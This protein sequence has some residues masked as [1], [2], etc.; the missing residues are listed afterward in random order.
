M[1]TKSRRTRA[2]DPL[3]TEIEQEF[4]LGQ[5]IRYGDMFDFVAGLELEATRN[6]HNE[7]AFSLSHMKPEILSHLGRKEDAL[8]QAW[9]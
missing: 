7:A 1:R 8:A 5:F 6:W 3:L 2:Q 9:S 4:C